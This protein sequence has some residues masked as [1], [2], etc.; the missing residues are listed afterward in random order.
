MARE[1]R[2]GEHLVDDDS[3]CYVIAE[4]GHNHQG[5]I[6]KAK[7]MIA[8][9]H[10]CGVSA[11]KLQKRDNRSLFTAEQFDAPYENENSFGATYGEH[12]E[13][14]EFGWDEYSELADYSSGLGVDFFATAFD[15]PSADFL[16][17]LG[18][19]AFKL[20]SGDLTNLPLLRHIAE[21]GKPI[22][23]STGGGTEADVERAYAAVAPINDQI[24]ILHCTASYPAPFEELN[25][26]VIQTL[27]DQ[28]PDAVIGYS[29]H[30]NGIV[31]P[32]VAYVLGA[33]VVEKHI[34]LDRASK[35]TDHAFSLERPGL[36]RMV[37]DLHNTRIALGDGKKVPYE[38]ETAPLRKMGKKIVLARSLE[39][40]HR[41]GA[42]DLAFKSPADGL[43]PYEIDN[44]VGRVLARDVAFDDTLR[45][46]DLVADE[47][48]T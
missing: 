15:F 22:I 9:A 1:L 5:S 47:P 48:V 45:W 40:G 26:R 46:E 13:N 2:I 39:K 37:R 33:R 25:L 31:A 10:E 14:L 18:V 43:A 41:L 44:V 38:S 32:V 8:A 23:F 24:C 6:E 29:S 30:D 28:F 3:D 7:E 27:R 16:H 19:P 35:G 12:R 42:D 36:Q 20:A 21:F 17:E 11:V 4:I 34:T